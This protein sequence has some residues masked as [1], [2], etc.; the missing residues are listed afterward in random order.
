[1]T[2]T[3]QR[4]VR[5]TGPLGL[6]ARP[7]AAFA[8]RAAR[9]ACDIAVARGDQEVDAKSVLLVLTLDVRRGDRVVLRAT[10]DGAGAAVEDLAAL[11]GVT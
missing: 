3:A 4:E 1:M 8:E 5:V 10:G 7:A 2:E 11:I 9:H 6:H